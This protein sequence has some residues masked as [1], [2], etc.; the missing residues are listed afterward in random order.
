VL[1]EDHDGARHYVTH[2]LEGCGF[3]VAVV[4][5]GVEALHFAEHTYPPALVL[6]D[7]F[8]NSIAVADGFRRRERLE[9]SRLTRRYEG[10]VRFA[11]GQRT[12]GRPMTSASN[13]RCAAG[14]RAAPLFLLVAASLVAT[15]PATKAAAGT[16]AFAPTCTDKAVNFQLSTQAASGASRLAFDGKPPSVCADNGVGACPHY[17]TRVLWGRTVLA[18]RYVRHLQ[19]HFTMF[20]TEQNYDFFRVFRRNNSEWWTQMDARSGNWGVNWWSPGG[21]RSALESLQ[22]HPDRLHF[23][24][25]T[26]VTGPG[27]AIDQVW[28]SCSSNNNDIEPNLLQKSERV[29]GVLLAAG[30]VVHVR[31]PNTWA[32][33]D[34]NNHSALALW[35]DA[36]NPGGTDFDLYARCG[37]PPTST[38]YDAVGFRSGQQEFLDLNNANCGSGDWYFAVQAYEGSGMFNLVWTTHVSQHVTLHAGIGVG[39]PASVSN[40]YWQEAARAWWGAYEG[41]RFIGTIRNHAVA[42]PPANR[43]MCGS[44]LVA[45]QTMVDSVGGDGGQ[46]RNSTAYMGTATSVVL[47]IHEWAHAF[48]GLSGHEEYVGNPNTSGC[49]YTIMTADTYA[50]SWNLCNALNHR[51]DHEGTP[52]T[53]AQDS[54]AA[55]G[56]GYL[57]VTPDPY[58]YQDFDFGGVYGAVT[59]VQ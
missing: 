19:Y 39:G 4:R 45:C 11:G 51:T 53:P 40:A 12:G 59:N 21:W 7:D 56:G 31:A 17:P 30:D 18:N 34:F 5:D 57:A 44:P 25:D 2:L 47:R 22:S 3:D 32:T 49:G 48:G 43:G 35:G 41:T 58:N 26:S 29:S 15:W 10:F 14:S 52:A 8:R 54:W 42:E 23:D 6:A 55:Q 36:N 9:G 16:S 46:T 13:D 20:Q 24:T 1:I 38:Q 28:V 37:A 33:G 27:F 50:G